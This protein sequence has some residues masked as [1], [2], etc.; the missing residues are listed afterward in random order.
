MVNIQWYPGHM[1]KARRDMQKNLKAVDMIVEVRDARIPMA[2]ANPILD[3]MANGKPRLIILSKADLADPIETEKWIQFFLKEDQMALALD[4]VNDKSSR[5]KAIQAC[6]T[7]TEKKRQRMIDRGIKPRAMRAMAC[8]IPNAGKSTF[9][10]RIAKKTIAKTADKP[11]VTRS[12][13]WIKA[14]KTLDLM[15]TP[16]VL[17]PKFEDQNVGLL[18]AET[19]AINDNIID[20]IEISIDAI[21]RIQTLYPGSLEEEFEASGTPRMILEGIARKR[22]LVKGNDEPDLLRAA[23]MFL[24]EFRKGKYGLITLE[25]VEQY[26]EAQNGE[27]GK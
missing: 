3:Q 21:E 24:K 27:E 2:S 20:S 26:E 7:L 9:I 11:G 18:L 25:Q 17:W 14:D 15:D 5:N 12:L 10:N 4:L 13:A 19:G 1:D 8:G 16:G 22:N 6:H 23:N